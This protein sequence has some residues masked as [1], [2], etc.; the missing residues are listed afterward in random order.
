MPIICKQQLF[1]YKIV[2]SFNNVADEWSNNLPNHHHLL[3]HDLLAI[4]NSRM[5]NLKQQYVSIYK[6]GVFIGC[7][8]IQIV[9]IDLNDISFQ[10]Q[11]RKYLAKL[12]ISKNDAIIIC[13]NILRVNQEGYFFKENNHIIYLKD[14]LLEIK[15]II[16]KEQ[17]IFGILLKDSEV[18]FNKKLISCNPFISFNTDATMQL[19]I[20]KNWQTFSDYEQSLTKKYKQRLIKIKQ[21]GINIER[22]ELDLQ[23]IEIHQIE[24]ENLYLQL[25]QKQSFNLVKLNKNY[26][27]EMKRNLGKNFM[28]IGYFLEDK[29]LAFSSY[30][31]YPNNEMEIHYIGTETEKNKSYQLYFNILYDGLKIAIDRKQTKLEL[32]RTAKE[33][34]SN[35]GAMAEINQNYAWLNSK[36]LQYLTQSIIKCFDQNDF[37]IWTQRNPFKEI[38]KG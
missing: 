3:Y 8:L 16:K 4:E 5:Q 12:L 18:N 29:M 17:N 28:L 13:G 38:N 22:R 19:E 1:E 27:V 37:N 6:K 31:F 24:I 7:L 10:S 21:S 34:K 20:R 15:T 23:A 36:V 35:M 9:K 11:F 26:F 33:A 25:V 32:G 30:I 14:I 2:D